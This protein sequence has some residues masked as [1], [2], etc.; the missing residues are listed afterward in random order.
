M[1]SVVAP[2]GGTTW[3]SALPSA[4]RSGRFERTR[5]DGTPAAEAVPVKRRMRAAAPARATRNTPA[6]FRMAAG[7]APVAGV[8]RGWGPDLAAVAP[9]CATPPGTA[10][11]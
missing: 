1:P 7:D 2:G 6:V 5:I 10:A 8:A 11:T 9:P 3:T 4:T